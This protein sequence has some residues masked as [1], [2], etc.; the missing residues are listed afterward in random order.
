MHRKKILFCLTD[1]VGGGGEKVLIDILKNIDRNKYE[2]QLCLLFAR[3]IL[4]DQIPSD[5]KTIILFSTKSKCFSILFHLRLWFGIEIPFKRYVRNCLDDQY[6]LIIPFMEG[7]STLIASMLSTKIKKLAWVHTDLIKN[8]ISSWLYKK[9]RNEERV[10]N[11]MDGIVFVSKDA[12]V[13]FNNK[14]K[15]VNAVQ[16][17]AYNPIFRDEIKSKV[18]AFKVDKKK[19][20]ICSLGRFTY[21]KRFDRLLEG[22]AY[23]KE[24]NIDFELW[25]V[26]DGNLKNNYLQQIKRLELESHVIFKGFQKNPYPYL[27]SADLFVSSSYAEGFPLV[28]C[29]A[30]ILGKPILATNTTGS[31]EILADGDYGLLVPNSTKGVK[32]GIYKLLSNLE[33]L[34]FYKLQSVRRQDFLQGDKALGNIY[35]IID[36]T[37]GR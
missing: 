27:N 28:M 1:L 10:Y 3:G 7:F 15:T 8:P 18:N 20:T 21:V 9:D 19:F 30:L 14:Y 31:R 16:Y 34:N 5:V 35:D 6:D 13:S 12:Q 36:S 23:L 32:D 4:L 22:C 2:A 26:G 25:I 29:E 33:L 17:I 37:I 24:K 11:K